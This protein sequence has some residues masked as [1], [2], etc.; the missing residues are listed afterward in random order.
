MPLPRA[1]V[2]RAR[3]KPGVTMRDAKASLQP[4][5]HHV[6]LAILD[7]RAGHIIVGV[8]GEDPEDEWAR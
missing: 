1:G 8:D 2:R 6:L 5:F 4:L 7:L 3:L